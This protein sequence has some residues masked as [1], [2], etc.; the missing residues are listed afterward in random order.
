MYP[1]TTSNDDLYNDLRSCKSSIHHWGA[2]NGV[3]FDTQRK[4]FAILHH[5]HGHGDTFKL[6][7]PHID[8]KLT[9]S[10]AITKIINKARPKLKAILRT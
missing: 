4:E 7:G 9:M 6:L 10:T 5:F 3:A 8:P 1:T 2:K